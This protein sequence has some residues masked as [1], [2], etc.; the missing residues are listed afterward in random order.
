MKWFRSY[1]KAWPL[2]AAINI[3]CPRSGVENLLASVLARGL[4]GWER[5]VACYFTAPCCLKASASCCVDCF[6]VTLGSHLRAQGGPS[7]CEMAGPEKSHNQKEEKT[8]CLSNRETSK[9]LG[10]WLKTK[11]QW[12]LELLTDSTFQTVLQC[13]TVLQKLD[14]WLSG[15]NELGVWNRKLD[16]LCKT[17][18]LSDTGK[19][20][21]R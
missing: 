3:Q 10:A 1:L 5:T 13:L 21:P 2:K 12:R 16:L 17:D 14:V 20:Q 11:E 7:I 15:G 8:N 19:T 4:L 18:H 9:N 6:S